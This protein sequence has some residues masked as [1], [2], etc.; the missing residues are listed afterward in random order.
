[1][2]QEVKYEQYYYSSVANTES[3]FLEVIVSVILSKKVYM[4]MGPI[5]SGFR[6]K[7]CISLY[8]TLYTVQTSNTP[9]PYTSC[10]VH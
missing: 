5:P 7:S 2:Q 3:V 8:S 4:Y 1:M 6:D 9:C 10:K